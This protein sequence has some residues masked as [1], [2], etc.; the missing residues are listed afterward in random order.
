MI[1][2]R[3]LIVSGLLMLFPLV[4]VA[5]TIE[6]LLE[7]AQAYDSAVHGREETPGTDGTALALAERAI[8][9]AGDDAE[10]AA[11]AYY[12]K[13][14]AHYT[15]GD[16][17]GVESALGNALDILDEAPCGTYPLASE[18]FVRLSDWLIIPFTSYQLSRLPDAVLERYASTIHTRARLYKRACCR[19]LMKPVTGEL[20]ML[21]ELRPDNK[22]IGQ[23]YSE[24][25]LWS[26]Q[27][28]D[29]PDLPT[30]RH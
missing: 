29:M 5:D 13:A 6:L 12:T 7:A 10:L 27:L 26:M 28:V 14:F 22:P 18:T 16:F 2:T 23:M 25:Q 17:D 21:A 19:P 11:L 15:S 24:V 4:G 30:D 3:L 8:R 1:P 9:E 20:G